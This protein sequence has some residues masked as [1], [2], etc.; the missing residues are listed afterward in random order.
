MKQRQT[1]GE[2]GFLIETGKKDNKGKRVIEIICKIPSISSNRQKTENQAQNEGENMDDIKNS[3]N[4]SSKVSSKEN[5]QN[6]AQND[7]F[8]RLD[9]IDDTLHTFSPQQ[10]QQKYKCNYCDNEFSTEEEHLKHCLN[11]HAK[12]PA[13]PSKSLI[14]TMKQNGERVELKGNPWE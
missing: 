11:F 8:G 13:Q 4:I 7:D 6:H 9:D 1:L 14:D 3:E 5:S 12:K 10:Q 2:S